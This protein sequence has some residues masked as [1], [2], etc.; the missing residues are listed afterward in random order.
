MVYEIDKGSGIGEVFKTGA[1]FRIGGVSRAGTVSGIDG[2]P[3]QLD[4]SRGL[5]ICNLNRRGD[6]GGGEY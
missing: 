5:Q 1:A 3:A 4:R 2:D 6:R